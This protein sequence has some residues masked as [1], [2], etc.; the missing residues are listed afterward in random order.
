MCVPNMVPL[1]LL[2]PLRL[3]HRGQ[4]QLVA[5][6]PL[7][8][9]RLLPWLPISRSPL[10]E[11]LLLLHLS[12]LRAP[13]PTRRLRHRPRR[14]YAQPSPPP[15][16]STL[17]DSY[18]AEHTARRLLKSPWLLLVLLRLLPSLLCFTLKNMPVLR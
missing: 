6:I 13:A 14:H 12:V 15:I 16:P 3:W 11:K 10:S 9:L 8:R 1:R 17:F 4:W 5:P 7:Q 18:L 2:S